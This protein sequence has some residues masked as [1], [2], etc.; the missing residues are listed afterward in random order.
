VEILYVL[1]TKCVNEYT[2][3]SSCFNSQTT[4]RILIKFG[5]K[6]ARIHFSEYECDP[7][8]SNIPYCNY[9]VTSILLLC[10]YSDLIKDC[11]MCRAVLIYWVEGTLEG[12]ILLSFGRS[13]IFCA[14]HFKQKVGQWTATV[15]SS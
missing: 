15:V 14:V 13:I 8:W 6:F 7:S 2:A 1:L 11:I 4:C 12:K 9:L 10:L 3:R 5:G